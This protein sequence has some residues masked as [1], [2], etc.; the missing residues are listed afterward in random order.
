MTMT[1]FSGIVACRFLARGELAMW[2]MAGQACQRLLALSKAT[3]FP[4]S[5]CNTHE[6]KFVIVSG[7]WGMIEV[8]DIVFKGLPWNVR[9]YP[10]VKSP[11]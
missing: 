5:I 1:A 11:H 9:K 6:L 8:Q 7:V 2:I 10:A 3:R 4:K